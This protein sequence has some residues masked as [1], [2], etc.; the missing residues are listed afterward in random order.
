MLSRWVSVLLGSCATATGRSGHGQLEHLCSQEKGK[1]I[2]DLCVCFPCILLGKSACSIQDAGL[3]GALVRLK[4][5]ICEE[6]TFVPF[7]GFSAFTPASL[8]KTPWPTECSAI[9][10]VF[11]TNLFLSHSVGALCANDS[12]I[13]PSF[14]S[15][16]LPRVPVACH[17]SLTLAEA[18]SHCL[19]G[20]HF[21]E[22]FLCCFILSAALTIADL[23]F[24]LPIVFGLPVPNFF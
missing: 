12:Q 7:S 11:S 19:K 21:T 14:L 2:A 5:G 15:A 6:K 10:E 8:W 24:N 3:S 20:F 13:K 23:L 1:S 4:K 9:K 22:P 18:S 17:P 16:F